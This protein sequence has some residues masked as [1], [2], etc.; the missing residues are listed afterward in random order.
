MLIQVY[1]T[2]TIH[3]IRDPTLIIHELPVWIWSPDEANQSLQYG[4]WCNGMT[5]QKFGIVMKFLSKVCVYE[6]NK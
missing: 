6:S 2:M 1:E 5:F 4:L 3:Y